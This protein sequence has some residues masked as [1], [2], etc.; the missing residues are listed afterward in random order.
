M[1]ADALRAQLPEFKSARA[2]DALA[3]WLALYGFAPLLTLCNH[4]RAGRLASEHGELVAYLFEP[5]LP[6]GTALLVHGYYDHVGLYRHLIQRLLEEGYTVAAFDL[7]G[8]GLSAG[9]RASIQDFNHYVAAFNSVIDALP[10]QLPRPCVAVGQST[11]A[12]ILMAYLF[13]HPA[14]H[15]QRACLLAPLVW[16]VNWCKSRFKY[17]I[18]RLFLTE[19]ARDFAENSHD[20]D[21]LRLVREG[22]PLQ[23]HSLPVAWVGALK[24]WIAR[25][26]RA[27]PINFPLQIIQGDEDGTVDRHANIPAILRKFPHTELVEIANGRHHLVNESAAL[28]QQVFD[29]MAGFLAQAPQETLK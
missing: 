19:V 5:R 28:R 7:P 20:P 1:H 11:G 3:P 29:A 25:F 15:F 6:K 14:P 17:E 16:P 13:Q 9:T 23:C 24:L 12:A 2:P 26:K 8:H 4:W 18:G 10:R 27:H 21:F 22:D